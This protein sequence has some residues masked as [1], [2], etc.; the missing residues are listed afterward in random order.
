MS[1]QSK[2]SKNTNVIWKPTKKQLEFLKAGSIFEVAYLGGAGSGKSSVLLVDAAR[3]MNEADAKAVVFRRTTRELRQLLDYSYNIYGRLGAKWNDHKS[4]WQFP[5]GGQIFFSHMETAA[6]KYQHDGQEYSA[7]VFFDEITSFEKD[8]YLYLHSRCRSTNP[9]LIPRVRCTGSPVGKHVDWVR[10]HFV[11]HGPYNIYKDPGTQLSRLYIPA[12]LD[13]NPYLMEA[14]K[15]YEQRLKMQGDKVYQ[16]LRYGD[17]T[18]IE[19]ICFPELNEKAHLI[20]T[21]TPKLNDVI[22]RAFDYG[23]SAPFATIWLAYTEDKKMICFKEYVGTLDGTNKGLQMP[24]NEVAKTIRDMEK[25]NNIVPMYCP[26]D[27]SMWS[28]QNTGESIA[29]IFE[30]EGLTMH[31][32][33][34]DRIYG[35]QQIHMRLNES[36]F[37][38]KPTLYITEDCPFTFKA[39]QQIMVDKRNIET[40]DTTGF[41]HPVDALRYGCVEIPFEYGMDNTP[42]EIFGDR[43]TTDMVF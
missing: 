4:K 3:Q 9:R 20:P 41:D 33:N 40:Y 5:S 26:A 12:T 38:T 37:T 2:T 42:P 21:Y 14:D 30:L 6:D 15:Q 7:G 10:T 23:F 13:D 31:R 16:A 36:D 25:A 11:D 39:L 1:R 29:E 34:N 28:R 35:T 17:W 8:Q 32:A 27:P 22:I 43:Q 19:G 24:A 18:K